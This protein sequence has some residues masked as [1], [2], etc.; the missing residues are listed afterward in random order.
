MEIAVTPPER[1]LFGKIKKDVPQARI[2]LPRSKRRM[3]LT[4][5]MLSPF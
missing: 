4:F 3:F 2:K 1:I 5:D